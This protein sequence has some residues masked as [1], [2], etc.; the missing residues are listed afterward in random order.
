MTNLKY[1]DSWY[2]NFNENLFAIQMCDF[3]NLGALKYN[4]VVSQL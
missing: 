3:F 2:P 4:V 1:F